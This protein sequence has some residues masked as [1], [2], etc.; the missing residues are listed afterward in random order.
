[1]L[2]LEL[3]QSEFESYIT[4][5]SIIKEPKSL[6][7]PIE[8][9][10][11]I[12]GKRLRPIFTLMVC[13]IFGKPHKNALDAALAVELFHNFSLMH[14]D[15]MDNA[16]LRRGWQTV[17]EKW[18]IN[19]GILSGD[20]L[21]ILAYQ[22]FENYPPEIFYQLAKLFSTTA[23][24]V[25]EG[26]QLDIDFQQKDEVSLDE[27]L[28]MITN[29]TAVLIGAAMAMGAIVAEAS[30][31][32]KNHIYLFGKNLGIAF[33]LQ[34]DYLDAFGN[35]QKFGKQPGG[36]IIEN[37]K[38][39]LCLNSLEN[40]TPEDATILR[41]LFSIQPQ[42]PADKIETVK[43]IYESSHSVIKIKEEI[44]R[45][46]STAIACLD[47]LNLNTENKKQLTDF[48][49]YLIDRNI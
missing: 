24:E 31:D 5:K 37:K 43:K 17:H 29:K 10:L 8:Y 11:N 32:E 33:Q 36:D 49:N 46:T 16:P 42:N 41:H 45:Y 34:D 6:Y 23:I 7:E 44:K 26:Q 2:S 4:Q 9:I 12:G 27:Y 30:E 14:D 22:L 48:A 19:T 35:S 1:M 28:L 20:A 38:T 18:D 21:L 25:C 39:F 13:A 15:I 3:Y 47:S 40:A